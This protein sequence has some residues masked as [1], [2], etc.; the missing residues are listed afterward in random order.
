MNRRKFI[1]ILC[2]GIGVG[3]LNPADFPN[4]IDRPIEIEELPET[5][6]ACDTL[7]A[8]IWAREWWNEAKTESYFYTKEFEYE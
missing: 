2:Y 3:F 4:Y 8:K 1:R 7:T 6:Q 5:F